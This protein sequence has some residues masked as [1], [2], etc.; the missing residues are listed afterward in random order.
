MTHAEVLTIV[1]SLAAAYPRGMRDETL[2]VYCEDLRD[3]DPAA[4]RAAVVYLRRTS[5]WLP[6]LAEIRAV[7]VDRATDFPRAAAAWH[8]VDRLIARRGS[9]RPP[10]RGSGDPVHRALELCGEWATVCQ[11]DASAL[12]KRYVAIYEQLVLEARA[13]LAAEEPPAWLALPGSRLAVVPD[14]TREE[15]IP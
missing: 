9:A 2:A 11:E 5:E 1:A 4:L 13:G 14:P 15:V 8:T 7:L 6:T 10:A 12:R 3:C